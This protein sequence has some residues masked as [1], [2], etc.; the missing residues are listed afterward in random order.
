MGL[1]LGFRVGVRVRV[2]V[3]TLLEGTEPPLCHLATAQARD[4]GVGPGAA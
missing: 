3:L 1:G 2:R 4:V